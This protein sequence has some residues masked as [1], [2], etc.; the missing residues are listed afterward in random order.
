MTEQEPEQ[1]FSL[2]IVWHLP[3]DIV[4]QFATDVVVQQGV[5]E[6]I[7]SFFQVRPPVIV[8]SPEEKLEQVKQ[9]DSIKA[10]CVARVIVTP[11]RM[12]KFIK[13]LQSSYNRY[14]EKSKGLDKEE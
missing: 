14:L 3:E 9:L 6:F 13:A 8:G 5:E 10:E 2:E 4:S 7:I 12:N 11:D 1:E